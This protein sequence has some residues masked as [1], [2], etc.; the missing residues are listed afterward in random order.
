MKSLVHWRPYL[1]WTKEPFTILTD[2]ANLQYWKSPRN[3]NW[4]TAHWHTDL[5]KYNYQIQHIPGKAN[6]PADILSHPPNADH[7]K[8]DNQNI[9]MLPEAKFIN[10][11]A[12]DGSPSPE[13]Q[14]TLMTWAHDHPTAGHPRH[15]ETL[16]RV[17]QRRRWQGMNVWIAEYVKGCATCQQ[18]KI[19][20]HRTCIPTYCITTNN[21]TLPFQQVA[22]DLITGLPLCHGKDAILTIVDYGCSRAAVFLP[23]TTT[24]TRTGIAQLYLD[25]IYRWFRLPTKVISDCDLCFTSHFG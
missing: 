8:D 3:L 20:T 23:C 25:N 6:M 4:R 21:D 13:E 7:G 22:M 18:N 1:G 14:Q 11:A 12:T 5:Q 24:I 9:T 2:H 17:K 19:I 10:R 15:N 16:R